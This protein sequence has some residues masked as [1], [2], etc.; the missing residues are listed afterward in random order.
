MPTLHP[1]GMA[2]LPLILPEHVVSRAPDTFRHLEKLIL[3]KIRMFHKSKM[4]SEA[5]SQVSFIR[6]LVHGV[7]SH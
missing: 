4:L 5:K 6:E 7:Q 2:T 3:I 1:L